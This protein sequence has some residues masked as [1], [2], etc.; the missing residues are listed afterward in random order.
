M[1]Y[2]FPSLD[3]LADHLRLMASI[4]R[5]QSKSVAPKSL[6]YLQLLAEAQGWEAAAEI[7]YRTRLGSK[8]PRG[9]ANAGP[10]TGPPRCHPDAF[11]TAESTTAGVGR[12]VC[13]VCGKPAEGALS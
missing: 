9:E 8:T 12:A 3:A 6:K 11:W 5:E 10:T 2:T 7:V 1:R 13:S 4:R